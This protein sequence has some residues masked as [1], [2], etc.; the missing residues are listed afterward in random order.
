MCPGNSIMAQNLHAGVP[1][2]TPPFSPRSRS[3][4]WQRQAQHLCASA[5]RDADMLVLQQWVLTGVGRGAWGPVSLF[6]LRLPSLRWEKTAGVKA[7]QVSSLFPSCP[8]LFS[9]LEQWLEILYPPAGVN[10]RAHMVFILF[11]QCKHVLF[12]FP[13]TCF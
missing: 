9:H 13:L 5:V 3:R 4:L 1:C 2:R 11:T 12:F 10:K 6:Y 7:W 8:H